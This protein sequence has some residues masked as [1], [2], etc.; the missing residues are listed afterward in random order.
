MKKAI[1]LIVLILIS[2]LFAGCLQQ[3]EEDGSQQQGQGLQDG[4]Q[5]APEENFPNWS[6]EDNQWMDKAL[7]EENSELC[8]NIEDSELKEGCISWIEYNPESS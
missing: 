7:K 3:P 8:Q 1:A 6:E 2:V 5:Q 4:G